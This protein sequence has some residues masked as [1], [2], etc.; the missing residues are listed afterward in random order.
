M[1]PR[2]SARSGTHAQGGRDLM[3]SL[4]LWVRGLGSRASGFRLRAAQLRRTGR[5]FRGLTRKAAGTLT[6]PSLI[7]VGRPLPLRFWGKGR[8]VVDWR[9]ELHALPSR[10]GGG[11]LVREMDSLGLP[12]LLG[13]TPSLKLWCTRRR[14]SR[15]ARGLACKAAR[16]TH[17]PSLFGA[18][19]GVFW[20]R[21]GSA[22]SAF[23]CGKGFGGG[24]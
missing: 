1:R 7:G 21:A 19:K 13:L 11:R 5:R 8:G 12:P 2:P 22:C 15:R 24:I 14:T 23:V 9:P 10:L 4:R 6:L 18:V 20:E 16:T 17:L 3:L